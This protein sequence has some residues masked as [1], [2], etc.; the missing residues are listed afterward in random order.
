MSA[1][2]DKHQLQV[3][4]GMVT[5]MSPFIQDLSAQTADLRELL[6]KDTEFVWFPSHQAAFDKLKGMICKETTP[7]H[8]D[9]TK[10]SVIQVD[11]SQKG[12]G[13]ALLQ[14][15]RPVA[16]ASKS[17]SDAETRYANIEREL[18]AVV[19]GCERFHTYVYGNK[20]QVDSDHKPLEMIT[21]KPLKLAPPRLQRMLLR[22]QPYDVEV[23]Y[24]E[25]LHSLTHSHVT[26]HA[27]SS[28][29]T[30]TFRSTASNSR[31]RS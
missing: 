13:A 11:A 27:S 16:F 23:L 28:T 30:S 21:R 20:F 3:F 14:D 25:R 8:F 15:G 26:Q 1:P 22:L 18:L 17:L 4:L 12:I 7:S 29:S 9:S 2:N 10:K 5:Y 31:R 6:K 19:F 24:R